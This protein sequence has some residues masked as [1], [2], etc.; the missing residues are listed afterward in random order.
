MA[1]LFFLE[2]ACFLVRSDTNILF[3]F[4]RRWMFDLFQSVAQDR[5]FLSQNADLV[6]EFRNDQCELEDDEEQAD[7]AKAQKKRWRVLDIQEK[8]YLV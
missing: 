3:W 1:K 7:D 6:A 5:D 8:S 2:W 4:I